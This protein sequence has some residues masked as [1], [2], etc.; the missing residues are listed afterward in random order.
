MESRGNCGI[1]KTAPPHH[2]PEENGCP[3]TYYW[4]NGIHLE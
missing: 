3:V 4:C 1:C 2:H